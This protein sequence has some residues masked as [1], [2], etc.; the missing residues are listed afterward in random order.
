MRVSISV[1]GRFHLF[2][3][4]GELEKRGYLAELITSYPKFAAEKYGVPRDKTKSVLS[5]E[6]LERLWGKTPFLKNFWSPQFFL[7]EFFDRGAAGLLRSSDI[8]VGASS[9]SLHTIRAAKKLGAITVLERGG[10]HIL[11][12][13]HIL[14]EEY[15]RLGMRPKPFQLAHPKIILKELQ[16]YAE[17]DYI[18]IPSLFAK[19]TFLEAGFPEGKLIH[20]PY[21]VNLGE[22]KPAPKEDD[23]FRVVY[24]GGMT[25]QKGVHYL[26][27]AF[28]ELNL[29]NSELLL[30]GGK[31]SE[32]EPFFKKYAG[33]YKWIG[34]VPQAELAK[35]YS[36]SSVFVLNSVHDGFGMVIIQA[37]A[38][39]LPVIATENTGGPD[40]I[41][42]G[43]NGF[44]I[45]IRDT[46][47][48]KEK[49]IYF[50][51]NPEKSKVMGVE[52]QKR[53]RE[54]FTW[55]D[56]GEKMAKEYKQMLKI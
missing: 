29:R 32:I 16:E 17:A 12:Q 44:I 41:K 5:K 23:V 13:D 34:R 19:E 30:I 52:A 10:A 48:L 26:L 28:A 11:F 36:G 33:R 8:F 54:G 46:A 15:K 37:M 2:N 20:V 21:G 18:S 6:I 49:L 53:A 40:I 51:R 22:F 14:K 45:P 27:Q 7:S 50:H 43:E 1:P 56:Y 38:C 24:A 9:A 42:E 35:Y 25:L 4:A 47:A 39:G 55:K 31:S 3:L